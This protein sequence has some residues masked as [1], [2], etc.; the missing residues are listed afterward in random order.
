MPFAGHAGPMSAVAGELVRRGHEVTA[1]TGAK[2][3]GR[4]QSVGAAWLPWTKATDF[5]D[6]ALAVTF[7]QLGDAKGVRGGHL[8]LK[9]VLFG[10]AAG[11]YADLH[12]YTQDQTF[13][14]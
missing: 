14:L 9:H 2:Y 12:A 7:P 13:D 6:S 1:Y 3:A 4:F 5:E 8:N 10:T 11:Q